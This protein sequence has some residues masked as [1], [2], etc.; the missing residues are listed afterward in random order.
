MKETCVKRPR[1]LLAVLPVSVAAYRAALET[2]CDVDAVTSFDGAIA[3][4][5]T[6]RFD[7]VVCGV[8]F[9]DSQMP[10]FLQRCKEDEATR[11][12]PFFCIRAIE[13]TLPEIMYRRLRYFVLGMGGSYLDF[14]A[15]EK[16]MGFEAAATILR[17]N[18]LAQVCPQQS[19]A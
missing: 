12:M 10:L 17:Q 5:A 11:D 7:A 3:A 14:Q 2:V 6:Q 19:A 8:N 1:I 16:Q 13:G 18:L 9:H 15:L 4:L